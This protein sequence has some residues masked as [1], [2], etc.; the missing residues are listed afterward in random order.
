[1]ITEKPPWGVFIKL[2]YCIVLYSYVFAFFHQRYAVQLPAFRLFDNRAT[3]NFLHYL[4]TK[5]HDSQ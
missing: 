2:L 5:L 4:K 3:A 1:M